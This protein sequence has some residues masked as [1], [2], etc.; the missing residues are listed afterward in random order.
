MRCP[1][2][3]Q[4]PVVCQSCVTQLNH[5][6][7]QGTLELLRL[8]KELDALAKELLTPEVFTSLID[9]LRE[10]PIRP[11]GAAF[12]AGITRQIAYALEASILPEIKSLRAKFVNKETN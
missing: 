5:A 6:N 4:E 2:C 8:R 3:Y 10:S 1:N 12:T 9:W 11:A 7:R